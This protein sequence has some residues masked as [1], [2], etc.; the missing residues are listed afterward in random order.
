MVVPDASWTI[1]GIR[2]SKALCVKSSFTQDIP[3]AKHLSLQCTVIHSVWGISEGKEE[4]ILLL[5]TT[6]SSNNFSKF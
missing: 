1:Y 5:F 2:P 4:E 3:E 6:L